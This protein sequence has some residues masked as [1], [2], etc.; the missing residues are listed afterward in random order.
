MK[1]QETTHAER[2]EI[3]ERHLAGETLDAIA[4][5][6]NL[7][8][9]TVRHWW[10]IYRD[11]GWTAL[12]PGIKGPPRVGALGRFHPMVK[13]VALRLKREHPGWGLP[14][15]RLWMQR[16]PSLQE[17]TLPKNTALWSY[18]HQ[19]GPR[20]LAPRRLF[21]K[22]PETKPLRAVTAHQCWEM[23]FKGEEIVLGCQIVVL[24]YGLTDE[25]SGAPLLRVIHVLQAKGN[26]RGLT[27]RHVQADLRQAFAQWGLPDAIRM[28][29]DPLF[30]GSSRFEW[31]GTLLL[32]LIGLGVQPI[33]NRAYRPTDNAMIE[34][35][36]RTWQSD[37]LAGVHFLDLQAV[38]AASDQAL[39]DRRLTLPS[40]HSGCDHR[41]PLEAFPDLV[42]RR[43]PY[44]ADQ[45]LS[46]FDL[47]R[48]DAYLAQWEWRRQVDSTGKI[49]LANRNHLID[50]R[51]KGQVVKVRFD[52]T[53]REFVCRLVSGDIAARLTLDEVS[54][55][56]IIGQGV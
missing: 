51:Y 35:A 25:A 37:V 7:N 46:L 44:G 14:M 6:L 11:D 39:E 40:R 56:Y 31:P 18:L 23:D 17:V 1:H 9:F 16:R 19:F 33:I 4:E 28:D 13:Y 54:L 53:T 55:E 42:K 3:V 36:N 43:R 26:H 32:W 49:S 2:V 15:L 38:Q 34:R 50:R 29:R 27:M 21:T 52:P 24:P 10:R 48:V 45:E 30:I 12:T 22:R 47:S 41:P 8:L 20:L 5:S